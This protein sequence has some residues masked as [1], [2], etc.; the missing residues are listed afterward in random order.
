[1]SEPNVPTPLYGKCRSITGENVDVRSTIARSP[2]QPPGPP[3][4]GQQ[5]Q[6]VKEKKRENPFSETNQPAAES[7]YRQTAGTERI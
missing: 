6:N 5:Q 2:Q 1:M 3:H 4:S 7:R